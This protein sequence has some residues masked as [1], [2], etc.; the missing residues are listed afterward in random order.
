[1][2]ALSHLFLRSLVISPITPPLP[3][4]IGPLAAPRPHAGRV[5]ALPMVGAPL[6][7]SHHIRPA[8]QTRPTSS[9]PFT[10]FPPDD[11]SAAAFPPILPPKPGR[12]A[13]P[14]HVPLG[15]TPAPDTTTAPLRG[16]WSQGRLA[17]WRAVARHPLFHPQLGFRNLLGVS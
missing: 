12:C 2:L 16:V 11:L 13:S 9:T 17:Q 6:P 7:T 15:R 4:R 10:S 5:P 1:M 14:P 8:V 3:P